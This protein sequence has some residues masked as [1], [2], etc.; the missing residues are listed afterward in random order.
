[1]IFYQAATFAR[2]SPASALWIAAIVA[3]GG[4]AVAAVQRAGREEETLAAAGPARSG[5]GAD[6]MLLDRRMANGRVAR[7]DA[8][9]R[10]SRCA[11]RGRCWASADRRFELHRWV[12]AG[13]DGASADASSL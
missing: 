10:C 11:R 7:L 9:A 5:R 2:H 6:G 12:E 13:A 8:G 4:L 1:M 3:P